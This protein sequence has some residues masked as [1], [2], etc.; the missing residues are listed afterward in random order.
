MKDDSDFIPPPHQQKRAMARL[1]NSEAS[2]LPPKKRKTGLSPSSPPPPEQ[3]HS[4]K[5]PQRTYSR[6]NLAEKQQPPRQRQIPIIPPELASTPDIAGYKNQLSNLSITEP[7]KLS[8]YI[9]IADALQ[10]TE[11]REEA[12]NWYMRAINLKDHQGQY[13]LSGNKRKMTLSKVAWL[14]KLVLIKKTI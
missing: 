13:V 6:I 11:A 4:R 3:N 8:L 7:E 10:K 12:L 14:N 1:P 2:T 5:L 9:K